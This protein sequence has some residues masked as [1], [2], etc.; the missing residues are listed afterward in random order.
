MN[1][2][3]W[4]RA[5]KPSLLGEYMPEMNHGRPLSSFSENSKE[6][7][8][9][10]CSKGHGWVSV[11][12][13]RK[14]CTCPVCANRLIVPGVNDLLT[15][16][17]DL[18]VQYSPE[19]E[20]PVTR[21]SPES[22]KIVLWNYPC[23]H[24]YMAAVRERY[25]GKGCKYCTGRAVLKGFNDFASKHPDMV[26]E[27]DYERN[28]KLPDEVSEKSPQ[29][30]YWIC[31]YCKKG[32]RKSPYDKLRTG[33]PYCN[34]KSQVSI[35]EKAIAFYLA[36]AGLGV[37]ESYHDR[38]KLNK[39]E[40]DIYI[41]ALHIGIEYDGRNY[42][43][44]VAKDYEKNDRCASAGIELIRFREVGCPEILHCIS[45]DVE[46]NDRR[47]LALGIN[48]LF[49]ILKAR[50]GIGNIPKIDLKTDF[51][52][53]MAKKYTAPM[54][55][56]L[57]TLYPE[58]AAMLH[59]DNNVPASSIPKR[60][61]AAFHWLCPKC[62]Y[63]WYATVSS[64][65][66]SA[67]MF[68][69]TGCPNC[70]RKVLI[71]GEND[72]ATL[73]P[74]VAAQ[75][76][77]PRNSDKPSDHGYS[78]KEKRWWICRRCGAEFEREVHVMVREGSR[79][80]CTP[81]AKKL[82]MED[83]FRKERESGNNVLALFPQVAKYWDYGKNPDRPEDHSPGSDE[84]RFWICSSCGE[85]YESRVIVRTRDGGNTEC[86]ACGHKRGGRRFRER[87]LQGGFNSLAAKYPELAKEWHPELNGT[88]KPSEIT[89]NYDKEVWWLCPNCGRA[90]K[91]RVV[92]R[93]RG[94]CGCA[95]CKGID[96]RFRTI[97]NHRF[98]E[99]PINNTT[100][101]L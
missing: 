22:H 83:R 73:Y 87:A 48:T 20:I 75:W 89:P 84:K 63:D 34:H 30:R 16:A 41:P 80:C 18:A 59:P 2:E 28:D 4:C 7:A 49:Q 44:D 68:N 40:I 3:E 46:P 11:V 56:S 99:I 74:D 71:R 94:D 69:R 12:Y 96:C 79:Y 37:V 97:N 13:T 72:I 43:K 57:E 86:K 78:S 81:C 39:M 42:H 67:T 100:T 51:Q 101:R 64:V 31:S 5:H 98:I 47:S 33:C 21:I 35:G 29:P 62:G 90:W 65:V 23:G 91:R 27:W 14:K 25:K 8:A 61:N 38:S 58:V 82:A 24:S 53:I 60:S 76:C 32:Y 6:R 15:L 92:V 70:A 55:N 45:I 54:E 36:E 10:I 19:N 26:D 77:Y 66:S 17:P 1:F 52:K 93:T 9:W 85:S 95:F 88:L 50:F